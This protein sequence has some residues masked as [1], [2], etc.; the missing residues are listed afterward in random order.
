MLVELKVAEVLKIADATVIDVQ[1]LVQHIVWTWTWFQ[2]LHFISAC[3]THIRYAADVYQSDTRP[4]NWSVL[5]PQ[6]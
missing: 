3:G 4:V 6:R 5:G 1:N 2:G